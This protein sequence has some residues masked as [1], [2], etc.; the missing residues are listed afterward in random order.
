MVTRLINAWLAF[1]VHHPKLILTIIA[2]ILL[3]AILGLPNFKLDASADSLTLENDP[4]L[5][6]FR[7]VSQNYGSGDFLVVTFTPEADLFSDESLGLLQRLHDDLESIEGI[8]SVNSILNVPLLYSPMRGLRE[9]SSDPR[10]LMSEGVDR[11]DAKK[12]F[13]TSPIYRD[14]MLGP[15]EKT[16]AIQL[17]FPVDNDYHELVMQRDA[18]RAKRDQEGLSEEERQTLRAISA[19]FVDYRTRSE[20]F[21]RGRVEA[22]RDVVANYQG[23]AEI[24]VGG[25]SMI[26]ADMIT[27]IQKDLV[28]FGGAVLLFMAIILAVI[29]R[30]IRFVVLPIATCVSAVTIMLGLLSWLDWRLTVISSNFVALLLIISLALIIYLIVRYREY[31]ADNP[32]WTQQKLVIE[33]VRF[34]ALPCLYTVLT[35]IVAFISLV[36][37]DI[38]PVIDF[39]WMM[40]IGL[41]VALNL[42][43]MLLPAILVL[44]P[45]EKPSSK[46]VVRSSKKPVTAYCAE[47]VE[48]HRWAVWS[49]S[50]TV[51]VLSTYG[52]T[53]LQVEN[54]FIDYFHEDTEIHQ[55]LKVI[56]EQLG[57]TTS[58]DILINA[59]ASSS[60]IETDSELEFGDEGDPFGSPQADDPFASEG[61]PFGEVDSSGEEEQRTSFWMT[62]TGL[63][64]LERVHD[65]LESLPE[66][67][68]VQSLA[69]LYK[70]GNDIN[71]GLNN[72]ELAILERSLP[73]EVRP[74]LLDPF[75]YGSE[76]TR[77]TLRVK[78][79]YPGLQRAELVERIRNHLG[80]ELRLDLDEVEF[81]GLLVLYNNMLQS[82]FHSQIV[83]IGAVFLG[84]MLMLL[85]LF[86]SLRVSM[87]AIIPNMVTATGVLG[88]MG[89]VGIPLDMMTIT[90]AAIAV[91]MGVDNSIHYVYRFRTEVAKD[92][93][94]LAAMH[95]SHRSIGRAMYYTSV[96]IVF[97][98]SI[99]ALSQF[100]P[101]IYFGLLTGLAM[102]AALLGALFLL[103]T[104]ILLVKPFKVS[105]KADPEAVKA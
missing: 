20:E 63:A 27:F 70:V 33:T 36:V 48:K 68:K 37:S 77:I 6:L 2:G 45:R 17:N 67:G 11:D 4:D 50:V 16:T 46:A 7:E 28:V 56:D 104:L 12:E 89:L 84:I 23:Q 66:V 76:Q 25:V 41:V 49:V 90:V 85:V 83:T 42:A 60:Y 62:V 57:G 21:S 79:S 10:T 59:K 30:S 93:D 31:A 24:F 65:Y 15:N 71:R 19:E 91:G 32:D 29:F 53:Q 26:A 81:S 1:V 86:R 64:Q 55:G 98:F 38:G 51:V 44:L 103:P 14:M 9:I 73:D 80:E 5:N 61:D 105:P 78:D 47:F 35:S 95:R 54:R 96:I 82:L 102:L 101:T 94:Y 34:M 43:F 8:E 99:M 22:V 92:G 40:A 72:F 75:L 88:M 100:I 13:L 18:L 52:F 87:V 3:V 69:T 97:G 58:L 74:V 39:G